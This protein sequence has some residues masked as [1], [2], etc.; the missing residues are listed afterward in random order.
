MSQAARRL[1]AIALAHGIDPLSIWEMT[2]LEFTAA[3]L[4]ARRRMN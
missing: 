2:A 3:C 4:D 1:I